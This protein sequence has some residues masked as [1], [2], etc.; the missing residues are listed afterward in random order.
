LVLARLFAVFCKEVFGTN[1]PV[2]GPGPFVLFLQ[3]VVRIGLSPHT[4]QDIKQSRTPFVPRC[5]KSPRLCHCVVELYCQLTG[6][7]RGISSN[8]SRCTRSKSSGLNHSYRSLSNTT[9]EKGK[10]TIV[11]AA[12]A[13]FRTPEKA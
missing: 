2:L 11:E 5:P 6:T 1:G 12:A 10:V 8:N 9:T 7:N 4:N 3:K 13:F